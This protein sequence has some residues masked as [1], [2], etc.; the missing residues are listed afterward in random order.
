SQRDTPGPM[1]RTVE[2]AAR[3]LDVI[4]GPDPADP[5]TADAD[6]HIPAT[7]TTV[8]DRAGLRGARI[9]VVRQSL[10]LQSGADPAVAALFE[11]AVDDLRAAGA[12]IVDDFQ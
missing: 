11:R 7:Y 3:L 10:R 4:A 12:S 1:A 2:D 9:G 8:L 5:R 6:Q